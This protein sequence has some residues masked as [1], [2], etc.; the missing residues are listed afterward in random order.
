MEI[1]LETDHVRQRSTGVDVHEEIDIA[2]G[3]RIIQARCSASTAPLSALQRVALLHRHLKHVIKR[4]ADD[5][6]LGFQ[7]HLLTR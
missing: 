4:T 1:L 3:A 2:V 7:Y 6:E 5:E